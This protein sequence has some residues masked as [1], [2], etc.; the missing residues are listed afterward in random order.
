MNKNITAMC[1]LGDLES[2]LGEQDQDEKMNSNGTTPLD[3]QVASQLRKQQIQT[4]HKSSNCQSSKL[5]IEV[6]LSQT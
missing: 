6:L 3:E 2:F 1:D 4:F 5:A